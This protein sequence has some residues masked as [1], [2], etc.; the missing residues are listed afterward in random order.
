[1]FLEPRKRRKIIAIYCFLLIVEEIVF[2][3]QAMAKLFKD[4]LIKKKLQEFEIPQMEEKIE[5]LK[6]WEKLY[7]SGALQQK[8]EEELE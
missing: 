2:R 4:K 1:M 5:V 7:E 6:N 8:K 3:Y